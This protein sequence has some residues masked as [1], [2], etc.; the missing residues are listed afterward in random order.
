MLGRMLPLNLLAGALHLDDSQP[1]WTLLEAPAPDGDAR[2]VRGRV[3]FERAFS[4]VPVVQV[5][6][7]GFDIDNGAN[8]RLRVGVSQIDEQGF[9]VE[10]RTWWNTRLWSVD[11]SWLAIG[12]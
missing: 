1:S 8:A 5:G 10:V 3:T 12:P 9:E 7:T 11:L 2:T 6:I 4:S